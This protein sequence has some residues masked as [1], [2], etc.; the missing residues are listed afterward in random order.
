MP[1]GTLEPQDLGV[2][3]LLG[4]AMGC[5]VSALRGEPPF[6]NGFGMFNMFRVFLVRISMF[7][8]II[9]SI[10]IYRYQY[11]YQSYQSISIIPV[12]RRDLSESYNFTI[13]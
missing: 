13:I 8:C 2:R 1:F 5:M 7:P 10:L 11:Q 9:I 4:L 12:V 6:Q 3:A